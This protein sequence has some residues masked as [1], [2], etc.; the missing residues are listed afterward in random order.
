MKPVY[1]KTRP[2]NKMPE[3]ISVVAG[4]EYYKTCIPT[5]PQVEYGLLLDFGPSNRLCISEESHLCWLAGNFNKEDRILL[6]NSK[7]NETITLA[8][9]GCCGRKITRRE[10]RQLLKKPY[11]VCHRYTLHIADEDW[12]EDEDD[13][14]WDEDNWWEI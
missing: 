13:E 8:C 11:L 12:D 10:L 1:L 4:I 14:D 2:N 5:D 3:R 9:L 7:A 6:V